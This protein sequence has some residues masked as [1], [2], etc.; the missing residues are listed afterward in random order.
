MFDRKI[1]KLLSEAT[2]YEEELRGACKDELS[3]H[4]EEL[5]MIKESSISSHRNLIEGLTALIQ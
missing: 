4:L 1:G 5:I 3:E 2:F